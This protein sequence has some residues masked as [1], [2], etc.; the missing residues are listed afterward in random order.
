MAALR[1]RGGRVKLDLSQF[2]VAAVM[3][4]VPDARA[5]DVTIQ[6]N[7]AADLEEAVYVWV[8]LGAEVLRVGTSKGPVRKRLRQYPGYINKALDGGKSQTPLWEAD[9]WLEYL[10]C[11][12]LHALVHQP[13]TIDTVAGPV[14]PYLDIERTLLA[15][16]RP[17]LNRS[18]R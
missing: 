2:R 3:T 12:E 1:T 18:H 10:Q 13:P 14:R 6:D 5:I 8:S 17:A 9:L 16:V 4:C 7:T 11:G 15:S